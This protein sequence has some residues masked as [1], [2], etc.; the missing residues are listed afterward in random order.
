MKKDSRIGEYH[1]GRDIGQ[2]SFSK[3]RLATHLPS[4]EKVA[5]K[6]IDKVLLR[7]MLIKQEQQEKDKLR[8][9][10]LKQARQRKQE[11]LIRQ[12]TISSTNGMQEIFN[13]ALSEDSPPNIEIS[14]KQNAPVLDLQPEV[15]LLMNLDHPNIVKIFQ[16]IDSDD[17]C[18]IVL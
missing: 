7:E 5:V 10:L 17:E 12:L 16:V 14:V 11:E 2:G 1:L 8:Q 6:I 18:Y 3:V 4:L 9:K 15:L 13:S